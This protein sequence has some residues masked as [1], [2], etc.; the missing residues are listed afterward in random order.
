MFAR[1]QMRCRREV[2]ELEEG[3]L[4]KIRM[5][6]VEVLALQVRACRSEN[7]SYRIL[8]D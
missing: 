4:L 1:R 7:E 8:D 6:V 3:R 5:S 2:R